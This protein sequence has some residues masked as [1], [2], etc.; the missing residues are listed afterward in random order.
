MPKSDIP[1]RVAEALR[2]VRLG[3]LADRLPRQLSGGQQQRVALARAL[4]IRPDVL[5]LDE[6]LSNLDAKLRETVRVEIRELQHKLG[7]TTV[8]VTHDQ[9][10]ALIMADRLVVMSEGSVRQVG[11]QR[12]LYERPADR[13]VAGFVGRSNL[14]SGRV[15]GP[16]RFETE[17]GV[18][19]A[20]LDGA[21]GPGGDRAAAG[22]PGAGR[23]RGGSRQP[24]HA[25]R[26]SSFPISARRST[27]TCACRAPTAS[28][29]TCRTARTVA[30]P[31]E[32]DRIDVGWPADCR[33]RAGRRRRR[34]QR[35]NCVAMQPSRKGGAMSNKSMQSHVSRRG[36]LK[37]AAAVAGIGA[38][39]A[40]PA[41]GQTRQ[42][43][44]AV[45]LGRRLRQAA[46]QARL[47]TGARRRGAGTVVNDEAQVVAA[48]GQDRR[49]EA[50]AQGHVRRSGADRDRHRRDDRG[51]TCW[52][53][54]TCPS[55]RMR[56]TSSRP[57]ASPIRR[58]F[59]PHIYSGKVVLYNPKLIKDVPKGMDALW[60]PKNQGKVG[61]VDI[62]HVYTT[63][64]AALVAGGK[65]GDFDKA[66]K[67][68]LDLKKLK[69]RIYPS[70][71]AL[72]QALQ[73]EEVGPLHHVEGARG[74]MAE[75]RRQ[76]PDRRAQGRPH[77]PTSRD[78]PFRRTR[79]TRTAPT[80]SSTRRWSRRCRRA[81]RSTWATTPSSR[82]AKVAPDLKERIGF[83]PEEEKLLVN[84]D[85]EFL[86]KRMARAEGLLG[87]G[88]QGAP[89]RR[90]SARRDDGV[91]HRR[92]SGVAR[93]A[94]KARRAAL[95]RGPADRAGHDLRDGRPAHSDRHPVPLQPQ[96]VRSRQADG[97]GA[98]AR[99]LRPV[100]HR[101]V[102]H[103][104]A[105]IAR[106]ASR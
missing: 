72:A 32:G 29:S 14:L 60:D 12:D 3:G 2:L 18:T 74:A 50:P 70:N 54:S 25:A 59:S 56:R 43:D 105:S 21:L 86:A 81:S 28:W 9:E 88:I 37:G 36:V 85:L 79:R 98:D 39:G 4:V 31:Q 46:D 78:S 27:C 93:R 41:F 76:H 100:L 35:L 96:P 7:I 33:G 101:P 16:G 92:Q 58:Y 57:S 38:L 45:H 51:R 17:A 73:T 8:M 61:I 75:R 69:P 30:L 97:R 104:R 102:L 49:R 15:I 83:T 65:T 52:R 67:A 42:E 26:S 66:K 82:N 62:Q 77:Q 55:S 68:L 10:E 11:S 40:F 84:P 89:E 106:C 23:G 34:G 63:M 87:Q 48:Q 47:G 13:F 80:R 6:P 20:C 90:T 22:A 53:S 103:R 19:I 91:G 5:L 24:A 95:D 44:R 71:E 94:R 99:E 1:P 64:A